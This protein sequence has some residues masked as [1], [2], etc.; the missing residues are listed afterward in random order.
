MRSFN[1][2][3][4]K[5]KVRG[6]SMKLKGKI[7]LFTTLVCIISI[8]S[9]SAI[10]F[11]VA[12]GRLERE[13]NEKSQFMADG[14]AK[15]IDKWMALQKDSLYETMEGLIFTNNYEYDFVQ[16]YLGEAIKR[17]PG[18]EYFI[19][20]SDKSLISGSGW[21]PDSDYDPT[22]REWYT[23]AIGTSDFYISEPYIDAMTGKMVVTASK[24]FKTIEGM[25]GV[26]FTDIQI[27]YLVDL[28]STVD[29]GEDSYA[30]LID[31]RE[32][33]ITH[34]ND[35]FKPHEGK[36][37]NIH[38]TFDGKLYQIIEEDNL[39]I[40]ARKVQ[41][42]DGIS[43][44]F[45]FGDVLES[46]WKV[47]LAV[48]VKDAVG[49]IDNVIFYTILATV[50][51]LIISLIVSLYISNSITKPIIETVKIAENIGN[52]NLLDTIDE[53]DLNRKDE[54]GQV[55]ASYNNIIINLK[56]FI[57]HMQDSIHT[58]HQIYEETME[59]LN[60]LIT[61]AEDTSATTEELSAGMEETAAGTIAINESANDIDRAVLDF[62]EKV[63]EGAITSNQISNKAED[64]NNQFIQAKDNTM[65]IYN[66]TR[67]E[68][69][70]AIKSS[71]EVEKINILSS[72][73]LEISEQTSLLALNAAIEAARAGES[74]RGFAVVADEIRKLA[75]SSHQTVEEIQEVTIGVNKVVEGLV[76]N[77]SNLITFL[78]RDIIDD[79]E[80]MVEAVKEYR[81]D[82]NNISNILS[83]LSATSEE[84]SA[85]INQVSS[86]INEISITVEESTIATTNIAEKNMNIVEA[87]ASIRDVM[88]KNEE[89]SDKLKETI[90]QVKL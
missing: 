9:I 51:V 21:V 11:K 44:F 86:S 16:G 74:G 34:I 73:I 75:E 31:D 65:D 18:N 38:N 63:E 57:K 79:Y 43:R 59:R 58:N 56:R 36:Q 49:A 8:L 37:I 45:L 81:E 15:D 2:H 12:I 4:F 66:A 5:R 32:N 47:G 39:G 67:K 6:I 24:A 84:L 27:D 62:A 64:L 35:E 28:I 7:V 83:E 77:A 19:A 50:I 1:I 10:N 14:I 48:S 25:Q 55:Y 87:I 82:G 26:A 72:A 41:D 85:T 76:S 30:F 71:K 13:I 78:E 40:R 70:E 52:L 46:N 22:S 20:F 61:Q 17:N 29:L 69:E 60:F 88:E 89:V 42:Y 54:I 80:M 33:I 3:Y 90:S 23:G 68:I 53:D